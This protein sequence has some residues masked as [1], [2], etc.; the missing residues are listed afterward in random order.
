[1][2]AAIA[3]AVVENDTFAHVGSGDTTSALDDAAIAL[4]GGDFTAAATHENVVQNSE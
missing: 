2:G 1:M 3:I 4:N